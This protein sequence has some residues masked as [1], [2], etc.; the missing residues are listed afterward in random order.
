MPHL[1]L[2]M[3]V[4]VEGCLILFSLL[5]SPSADGMLP[6]HQPL[7]P[8][9]SLVVWVSFLTSFDSRAGSGKFR[10]HPFLKKYSTGNGFANLF[11]PA[12]SPF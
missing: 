3:D 11:S 5:T 1:K 7:R 6:L 9:N 12:L 2:P 10:F 8:T 4:V